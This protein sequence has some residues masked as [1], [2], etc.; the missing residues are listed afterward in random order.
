[1]EKITA[2][3]LKFNEDENNFSTG[4]DE[5]DSCLK[6][7]DKGSII[8]I[9]GRPAMGKSSFAVSILNNLLEQ[10]KKIFYYS[11]G[12]NKSRLMKRIIA[13]RLKLNYFE[14]EIK[15]VTK[16][17]LFNEAIKYYTD[18]EF[19]IE[20]KVNFSVSDIEEEIK[21]NPP[22]IVF[23]DYIQ[24]IKMPKAPNFTD[25]INI[26]VQ[27]IKRIAH[28]TGVIFVLLTQLSRALEQRTDKRPLPSDIR[29]SSLLEELSDVI[30]MIYR[31]SYYNIEDES[32]RH[33]AEI[34]I[35]K[36]DFGPLG[37]VWMRFE[38]GYFYEPLHAVDF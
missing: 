3:E 32:N 37:I 38:N 6:Y 34:N 23:I 25:S 15:Q 14:T 2:K 26:A 30:M 18:K 12:I 35:C 21:K 1:M 11:G 10:G 13:N 22:D 29:S 7:I 31:D 24:L 33:R 27:E 4:F 20:D 16:R 9:G 36:H 28:Q 5:I 8:T 19:Y 17:S